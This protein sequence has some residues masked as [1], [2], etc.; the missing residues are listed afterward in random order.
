M[1]ESDV[2]SYDGGDGDNPTTDPP[3]D[4]SGAMW[5]VDHDFDFHFPLGA[6][7][8]AAPYNT[9]INVGDVGG[10]EKHG[11][12]SDENGIHSHFLRA[13]QG[14]VFTGKLSVTGKDI[15]AGNY[16]SNE[17]S[18]A[19]QISGLGVGHNNMPPYIGVYFIKRTM[20]KYYLPQ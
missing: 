6:G 14:Q 19:T 13:D 3:T 18:T 17:F 20:R 9:L 7:T 8:S 16:I 15:P 12:T 11:L 1:A 4:K 10:E 2:W 5:E